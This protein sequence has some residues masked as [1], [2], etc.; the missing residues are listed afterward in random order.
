M[1]TL[2][3]IAI[4]TRITTPLRR[5]EFEER[6]FFAMPSMVQFLRD[7]LPGAKTGV[8]EATETPAAQMDTLLRKW[9]SGRPMEYGRAFSNLR[10]AAHGVW[11]M[12]TA[13]LRVFG[14]IYR[15][16][17]FIAT[18]AG[19]ADDYKSQNGIPPKESYDEARNRV[20][21]IRDRIALDPPAF[22]TGDYDA[23]I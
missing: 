4:L 11:E 14:W 5:R 2:D 3:K 16:K 7:I 17:I 9:N 20:V 23:L 13:D 22:A 8:V 21:W 1:A 15:P 6:K 12:K 10:P 19:L 18:F